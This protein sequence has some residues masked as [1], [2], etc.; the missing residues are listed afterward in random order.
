[1]PRSKKRKTAKEAKPTV[2]AARVPSIS[3]KDRVNRAL[4]IAFTYGQ[5]NGE[6]HKLWVIDQMVQALMPQREYDDWVKNYEESEDY[7]WFT[8]VPI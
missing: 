5:T 3:L 4:N 6:E 8:G 1:M 7:V 2:P